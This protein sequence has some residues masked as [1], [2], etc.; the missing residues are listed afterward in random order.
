M[1]SLMVFPQQARDEFEQE[2]AKFKQTQ[3]VVEAQRAILVDL[4]HSLP[5]QD[6]L[7]KDIE[8]VDK[9]IIETDKQLKEV[10]EI[11]AGVL[12]SPKTDEGSEAQG[13]ELIKN[14]LKMYTEQVISL[15]TEAVNQGSYAILI[16]QIMQ[17][18]TDVNQRIET[19]RKNG[20]YLETEEEA[21]ARIQE[22]KRHTGKILS[23]LKQFKP[24]T[25]E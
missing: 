23:F 11:L 15:S 9:E 3:E 4:T 24:E 21:A 10:Q 17:L 2:A 6:Q 13:E 19:F 22:L 25:P 1:S 5:P 7:Q 18:E 16:T 14:I 20:L 8:T 12:A